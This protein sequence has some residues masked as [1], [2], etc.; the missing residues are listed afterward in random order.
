MKN[1][2]AR[3][4]AIG[5]ATRNI[6]AQALSLGLRSLLQ[7]EGINV[8]NPALFNAAEAESK[9][10]QDELIAT[11]HILI[12]IAGEDRGESAA[13]LAAGLNGLDRNLECPDPMTLDLYELTAV[14]RERLGVKSLPH[15]LY[16]A[17]QVAEGS[18]LLKSCLGEDIVDKLLETKLADY[19]SFRLYISPLDLERHMGL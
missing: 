19:E 1:C 10:M 3:R 8:Q 9:R 6:A 18:E 11:E 4:P 5:H 17:I 2:S 15:D 16:E 12:A 14:E 7:T 13:I